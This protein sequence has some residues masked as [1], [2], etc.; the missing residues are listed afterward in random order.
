M[1]RHTFSIL[2]GVGEKIERRLWQDGVLTWEDFLGCSGLDF[3]SS[4]RKSL[5]DEAL[6]MASARLREEDSAYFRDRLRIREHWRLFDFFRESAVCLDIETNGYPPERGGAPTV[7]GLYDGRSYRCLIQGE[8][9]TAG[10][11]ME[12]LSEYK[13]LVTFF[14]SV[15]DLPFL[16][17]SLPGFAPSLPHLDLCFAARRLGM[18]GGLKRIE[19]SLGIERAEATRGM[20]GYDAVLLWEQWALGSRDALELLLMYNREDTVN[21]MGIADTVYRGLKS[22]TGIEELCHAAT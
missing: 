16:E 3:V 11:L 14:G 5:Y 9:L 13:Y 6:L 21:L 7:V 17:R 19:T 8:G 18:R 20:D 12:L 22:L 4:R 2:S 10:G 15:F 1:I